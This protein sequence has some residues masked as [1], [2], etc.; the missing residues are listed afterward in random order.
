MAP[1][2]LE[3]LILPAGVSLIHAYQLAS[4]AR[5]TGKSRRTFNVPYPATTGD[6]RF[7]RYYRAQQNT[8]E[9]APIFYP[10]LWSAALFCHQVPAA[11]FGLVY[12]YGRRE[13]FNGYIKEVKGRLYGFGICVNAIKA[14][15]GL[16][17]LGIGHLTLMTYADIDVKHMIMARFK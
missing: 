7:M 17:V 10:L 16:S 15:L 8:I 14:L 9:F 1:I 3:N 11:L 5:Q 6:E 4:F 2:L 13:Y 12:I